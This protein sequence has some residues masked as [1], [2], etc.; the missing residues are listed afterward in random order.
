MKK[1]SNENKKRED[2]EAAGWDGVPQKRK[3]E[4][5]QAEDH[6]LFYLHDMTNDRH[7]GLAFLTPEGPPGISTVN[8]GIKIN[9]VYPIAVTWTTYY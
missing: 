5:D 4:R 9:V 7:P 8:I 3:R 2:K 6:L 1:R